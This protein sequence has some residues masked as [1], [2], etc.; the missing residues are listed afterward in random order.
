MIVYW[1]LAAM[2]NFML[3]YLLLCCTL[4]LSGRPIR[5]SRIAAAAAIGAA[6]AAIQA[7]RP[8]SVLL[9][10]TAL[11]IMCRVA[12]GPTERFIQLTLLFTL[13]SCALGGTVLLL[14]GAVGR[15][16]GEQASPRAS[17]A[18]AVFAGAGALTYL[19]LCLVFRGSARHDHSELARV[20]IRLHGKSVTAT[21]LRD[22]GNTL[23][24][25]LSGAGV[26]IVS[27]EAVLPLFPRSSGIW[28]LSASAEGHDRELRAAG[29]LPLRYSAVGI[30]TGTL[31][32][33]R[34]SELTL[35]G[36]NL[37]SR[38]IA[39][40]PQPF[41]S[42]YQGL[43]PGAEREETYEAQPY[44]TERSADHIAS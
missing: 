33:F 10:F 39:I 21:L 36:R 9:F 1:D 22:T 23:R 18:A 35:D 8:F 6:Y 30:P 26:P 16:G 5:R 43:W 37:G 4:R 14:A 19:L 11:L 42:G 20:T 28:L 2:W 3:D 12:F 34:C 41:G 44:R 29:F 15:L 27:R 17:S 24:D 31:C 25:P 13:L 40:S 38:L 32:A 7:V